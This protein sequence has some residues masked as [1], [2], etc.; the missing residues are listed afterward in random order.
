MKTGLT[1][2]DDGLGVKIA[3]VLTPPV[4]RK[5]VIEDVEVLTEA[6]TGPTSK[7]EGEPEDTK[8]GLIRLDDR[9]GVKGRGVPTVSVAWTVSE[10][11]TDAVTGLTSKLDGETDAV[12]GPTSKLLTSKLEDKKLF[13]GDGTTRVLPNALT[14]PTVTVV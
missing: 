6:V 2:G 5:P 3:A 12:I 10:V 13:T 11:D 9:L 4:L 1:S 7:L 8:T 14:G